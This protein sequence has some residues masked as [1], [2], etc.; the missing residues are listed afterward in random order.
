MSPP[1]S[2]DHGCG[3]GRGEVSGSVFLKVLCVQILTLPSPSLVIHQA[4][5]A[6]K[7]VNFLCFLKINPTTIVTVN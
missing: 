7:E 1:P 5:K 6:A 4:A 3:R 2:L